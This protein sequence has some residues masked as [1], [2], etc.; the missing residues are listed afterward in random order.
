[1]LKNPSQT[2]KTP[3]KKVFTACLAGYAVIYIPGIIHLTDLGLFNPEQLI[4]MLAADAVK[5]VLT[6]PAVYY[7]RPKAAHFM[8]LD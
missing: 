8:Q 4:P 7:L 5:L 6:V 2:G 3:V 1:M